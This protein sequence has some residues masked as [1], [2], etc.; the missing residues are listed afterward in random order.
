MTAP[1]PALLDTSTLSDVMR[2]QD[3][4]VQAAAAVYLAQH[5][6]FTFSILSRY[7]ILRGLCARGATQQVRRFEVQCQRSL[8]LPLSDEIIVR[9]AVLYGEL[10]RR[11][12]LIGDADILSRRTA[13]T[14]SESPALSWPAGGTRSSSARPPSP[15]TIPHSAFHSGIPHSAFRIP[16]C[17][18]CCPLT[19][20][21]LR[22]VGPPG[23]EA[24]LCQKGKAE[25][26]NKAATSPKSV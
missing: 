11:G 22:A 21:P 7:E 25:K 12:Q 10:Y 16:H 3:T 2:G 1:P 20:T 4:S 26:V 6:Q 5:G 14:S 13:A 8:L 15:L 9:A 17:L 23:P 19:S 24:A 18:S